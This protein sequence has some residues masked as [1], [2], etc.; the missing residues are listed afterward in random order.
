MINVGIPN[1]GRLKNDILKIF[2]KKN[3][4]LVSEGGKRE[5]KQ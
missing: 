1:K 5:F 3:L 2:K 4:V